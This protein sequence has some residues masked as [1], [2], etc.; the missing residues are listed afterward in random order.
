MDAGGTWDQRP[1]A[2]EA[3][4]GIGSA[5]AMAR[6]NDLLGWHVWLSSGFAPDAA[7]PVPNARWMAAQLQR[8]A[9]DLLQAADVAE[10]KHAA[11][12]AE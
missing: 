7:L 12:V 5:H 8:V 3:T 11:Q 2:L 10:G 1:G 9:A 4:R 6:H